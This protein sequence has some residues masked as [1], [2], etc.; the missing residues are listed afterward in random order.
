[1]S[2]MIFAAMDTTSNALAL[3]LDLLAQHPDVQDKLRKEIVEARD[4][5]D[6]PYD[7][8]VGLPYLDAVCRETLRLHDPVPL[9]FRETRN[10]IV[11][12][13]SE[14]IQ[15]VDGSMMSEIPIPK[16]TAIMVGV[17]ASNT[18]KTIWGDD[19]HE[20]KPERWLSPLP[21]AVSDA[22]IPGIYSHLMTFLGGG[23]ACIGFK[24]SQLEMKVVLSL[25]L[26]NFTFELSDKPIMWNVAGVRALLNLRKLAQC[27]SVLI[28][29]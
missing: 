2:T 17:M 10:D 18:S 14:P 11:L 6:L 24:F 12:P 22:H 23:R 28:C 9:V 5:R 27:S 1:M 16:D 3:T 19:A 15:G 26:S 29:D 25:L 7:E 4:G 21:S 8:L 13:L 20:W